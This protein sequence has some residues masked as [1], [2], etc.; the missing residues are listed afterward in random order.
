S[1]VF[2]FKASRRACAMI[3]A[4]RKSRMRAPLHR[5]MEKIGAC[6]ADPFANGEGAETKRIRSPSRRVQA[7][8]VSTLWQFAARRGAMSIKND[9]VGRMRATY[10]LPTDRAH[11]AVRRLVLRHCR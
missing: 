1:T 6:V 9:A 10:L 4:S 3:F 5:R 2:V 11:H 7:A 8:G